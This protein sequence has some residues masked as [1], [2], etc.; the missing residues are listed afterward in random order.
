MENRLSLFVFN[1]GWFQCRPGYFAARG[2]DEAWA[3]DADLE[4]G[5]CRSI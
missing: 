4:R 1:C 5:R 3:E 2:Y